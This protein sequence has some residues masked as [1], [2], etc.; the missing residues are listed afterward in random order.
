MSKRE[1]DICNLTIDCAPVW[2]VSDVDQEALRFGRGK[3]DNLSE[4]MTDLNFRVT[5]KSGGHNVD[6]GVSFD[7]IDDRDREVIS[8]RVPWSVAK[9]IGAFLS[10]LP[11]KDI[12]D[13]YET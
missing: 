4:A 13:D 5:T 7:L 1:W 2:S 8:I 9:R 6:C 3:H 10:S 11:D 12:S